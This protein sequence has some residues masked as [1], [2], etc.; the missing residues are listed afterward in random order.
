MTEPRPSPERIELWKT[1]DP[2]DVVHQVVAALAQGELVG[3]VC[4]GQ[5]GV[6]ASAIKEETVTRLTQGQT[7]LLLRGAGELADWVP[8]L[9]V[10]THRMARRLW[11]GYVRLTFPTPASTCL[12]DR[13]PDSVRPR[14]L[15]PGN[16]SI[17]VPP[18]DFVRDVLDLLPGPVVFRANRDSDVH[19][20]GVRLEIDPGPGPPRMPT[21]AQFDAAGGWSIVSPGEVD[22]A[23]LHRMAGTI[24]L[25]ICTGN[26]CRSPMAEALCKVRLAARLGCL[27]FHLE[28][29]G[30]VILSAGIAAA[31]GM[32]AASNAMAVVKARGGSLA[33]H[34]SRKLTA[35]LVLLAD[36]IFGM[37]AD[38]ID[39]LLDHIPE[40]APKVRVLHPHGLDLADPIGSDRETYQRTADTIESSVQ[41]LA[42]FA[43]DLGSEPS[44]SFSSDNDRP[45]QHHSADQ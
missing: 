5:P 20:N 44:C 42:R 7:T 26:T 13:L 32:P 1:D 39:A 25:F 11:P 24:I 30:Y 37:T 35:E 45:R 10:R 28:Q 17:E 2:R 36:H 16:L 21:V 6:A 34:Q 38:H 43:G 41:P 23:T 40:A 19:T 29:N 12:L 18:E 31:S 14:L 33:N 3:L 27:P 4:S 15:N 8:D 22:A 9:P